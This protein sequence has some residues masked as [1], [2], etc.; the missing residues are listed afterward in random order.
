MK[1]LFSALILA[2]TLAG[3]PALAQESGHAGE[4]AGH[5]IEPTEGTHGGGEVE[6]HGTPAFDW[7]TFAFQMLN[8]GILVY[9]LVKFGGGA[10]SKALAER[11]K[12]LKTDVEAANRAR[13]A[14]EATLREQ[15]GRLQSLQEE[16][17]TLRA[18]MARSAEA[19]RVRIL[20]AAA[21][22]AEQLKKETAFLL[23]QQ[24][25]AAEQQLRREVA[26]QALAI[27]EEL[28]RKRLESSD[29]QRLVNTFMQDVAGPAAAAPAPGKG[30]S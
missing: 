11:H 8:F 30:V 14:A 28:L 24:V 26:E 20:A 16:I 27:A 3:A 1:R 13:E 25:R 10:L 21:Q 15:E 19:D 23:D 4:A 29:Q 9:I 22:R 5:A 17:A 12:Q 18:N 7:K 2:L 6:H